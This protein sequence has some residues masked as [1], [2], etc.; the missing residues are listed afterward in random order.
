MDPIDAVALAAILRAPTSRRAL[1]RADRT[2]PEPSDQRRGGDLCDLLAC[3]RTPPRWLAAEVTLARREAARQLKRGVEQGHVPL[4]FDQPGYPPALA[5]IPDP[6]PVLWLLGGT[7]VCT[8]PA[9]AI[10]GSRAGSP[11]ACEVAHRLGTDLSDRGIAVVSGLARGVDGA[12]HQGALSGPGGTIAVLGSGLDVIYPPEHTD[13]AQAIASD[14]ALVSECPPGALPLAFHFPQRNRIIS[15]L[16][17]AVVVVEASERS[18]S[19]I[20][21]RCAAD[22]GRE[23]MA[24]PGNVL[25]GRSRGGHALIKD[26]AKVVETADDIL[27]EIGPASWGLAGQR[28]GP[29]QEAEPLLLLM[30]MGESYDLDA[31]AALSG[32]DGGELLARVLELELQGRVVRCGAGRFSRARR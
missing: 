18:G 16:A 21:A 17:R 5:A 6:P 3:I 15:G 9:V 31:L 22:Q 27:E 28:P 26:G 2:Q 10:V 25:T 13:L 24:V 30:D 23:V 1:L 20:T 32:L 7:A 8:R 19:L 11:Y 29:D 12:A 14:G 4:V